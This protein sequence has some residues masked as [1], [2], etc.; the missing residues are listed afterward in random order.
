MYWIET[1]TVTATHFC[2]ED[3]TDVN[4]FHPV[5]HDITQSN[6]LNMFSIV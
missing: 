4:Q 6:L 2:S 5:H 3:R 1:V